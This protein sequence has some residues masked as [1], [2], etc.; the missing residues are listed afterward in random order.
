VDE[1]PTGGPGLTPNQREKRRQIVAA[2]A[3]VL[4]SKGLAGCTVREV[5]AAGPLTKSAVHYYFQDMEDLVE[6]AM[7]QHVAGLV[8]ILRRAAAPDDDPVA[9]L[10]ATV[11]TFLTTF[12]QR[13]HVTRLWFEYWIDAARKD[14]HEAA[15][16]G[17]HRQVIAVFEDRLSRIRPWPRPDAATALFVH[18]LGAIVQ[19]S[20]LPPDADQV[21]RALGRLTGV[22]PG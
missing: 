2:A 21:R 4:A 18:L 20:V 1:Y 9:A 15:V 3:E 17:M 19:Q 14:R 8:E 12:R 10:W 16:A 5:A 22:P 6:L 7:A 13:P 11:D